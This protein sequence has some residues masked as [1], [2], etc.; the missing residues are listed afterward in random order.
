MKFFKIMLE[1]TGNKIHSLHFC[2]ISSC[3]A[4]VHKTMSL[5]KENE[6]EITTNHTN[7]IHKAHCR[8]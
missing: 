1:E 3:C 4:A 8:C 5:E 7:E 6:V 2:I